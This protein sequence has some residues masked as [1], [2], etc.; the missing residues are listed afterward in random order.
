MG[1]DERKKRMNGEGIVND[2]RKLLDF[3][4]VTYFIRRRISFAFCVLFTNL[5][6]QSN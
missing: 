3:M 5:H 4:R 1:L 2:P 6:I